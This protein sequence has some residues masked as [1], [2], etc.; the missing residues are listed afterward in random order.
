MEIFT[1]INEEWRTVTVTVRHFL[2][3]NHQNRPYGPCLWPNGK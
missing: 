3:K 1:N 2:K